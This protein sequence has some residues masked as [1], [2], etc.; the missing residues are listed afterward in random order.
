MLIRYSMSIHV[1]VVLEV[2]MH[3][4][5]GVHEPLDGELRETM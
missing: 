4:W 1:C 5:Q 3:T 2:N